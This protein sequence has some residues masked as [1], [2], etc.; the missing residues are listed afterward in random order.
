M[1]YL[2]SQLPKVQYLAAMKRKFS[3]PFLVF[4]SRVTGFVLGSFFAVAHYQPYEWNRKHTSECNRAWGFV[5]ESD[6]ELEICFIRGKGY[7]A[8]G[9]LAVYTIFCWLFFQFTEV[10]NDVEMGAYAWIFSF[11]CAM[12]ACLA[13][14]FVSMITE[15]GQQG[16]QE[17]NKLL[18]DPENYY[19]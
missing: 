16:V 19:C 18:Q 14:A 4:D 8:P 6:G 2:Y 9:W 7:L 12:I 15:A 10:K 11:A 17:V 1:H 5:R 13:S 3:S